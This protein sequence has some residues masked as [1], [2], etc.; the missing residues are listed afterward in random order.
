MLPRGQLNVTP[1]PTPAQAKKPIPAAGAGRVSQT[2]HVFLS[3]NE[4]KGVRG[5]RPSGNYAKRCRAVP[6]AKRDSMATAR[7]QSAGRN[8]CGGNHLISPHLAPAPLPAATDLRRRRPR[9]LRDSIAV[10][11]ASDLACVEA[12]DLARVFLFPFHPISEQSARSRPPGACPSPPVKRPQ[13]AFPPTTHAQRDPSP[14]RNDL[15]RTC[16]RAAWWVWRRHPRP[17]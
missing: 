7:M 14:C 17:A 8:G 10:A 3:E 11:E 12:G 5:G 13:C 1:A 16:R 9:R 2:G 4:R 15:P 6:I